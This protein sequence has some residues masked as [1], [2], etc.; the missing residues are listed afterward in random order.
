MRR[1]LENC[2]FLHG[3]VYF[4]VCSGYRRGYSAR[5]GT[6]GPVD[7][8]PS[9]DG[10]LGEMWTHLSDEEKR[11]V[12]PLVGDVGQKWYSDA[13]LSDYGKSY[14]SEIGRRSDRRNDGRTG[15]TVVGAVRRGAKAD[16][17]RVRAID[18]NAAFETLGSVG[19]GSTRMLRLQQP[20]ERGLSGL[21]QQ[22]TRWL[23]SDLSEHARHRFVVPQF[24]LRGRVW[25]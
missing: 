13:T 11:Q 3:S 20:C 24:H 25:R 5:A 19:G 10:D 8:C 12:F 9:H 14:E 23:R 21:D 1:R 17:G 7:R 15:Q 6:H 2:R 22:V 4:G 16:S 18:G